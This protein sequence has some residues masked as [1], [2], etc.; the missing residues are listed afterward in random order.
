MEQVERHFYKKYIIC[1]L[2]DTIVIYIMIFLYKLLFQ[3]STVP[4]EY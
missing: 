4:D 3:C 1:E 2:R